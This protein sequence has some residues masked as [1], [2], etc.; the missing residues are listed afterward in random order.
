MASRGMEG[1]FRVR[2]RSGPPRGRQAAEVRAGAARRK[3]G[4]GICRCPATRGA[5]SGM[6]GAA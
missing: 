6:A 4:G 1:L 5:W 3:D 2:E